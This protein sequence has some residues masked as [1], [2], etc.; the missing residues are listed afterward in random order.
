MG[1]IALNGN[2]KVT[3]LL[4]PVDKSPILLSQ[5]LPI[6]QGLK[7]ILRVKYEQYL[8]ELIGMQNRAVAVILKYLDCVLVVILNKYPDIV[9]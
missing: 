9:S 6:Y 7:M 2:I 8:A 3:L 1:D 4:I 5:I